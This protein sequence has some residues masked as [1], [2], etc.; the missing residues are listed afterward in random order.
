MK[1]AREW[2]DVIR[3]S[4][5]D[6]R[7]RIILISDPHVPRLIKILMISVVVGVDEENHAM[8]D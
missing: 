7:V 2:L 8:S 4:V 3:R 1:I 6:D 5:E